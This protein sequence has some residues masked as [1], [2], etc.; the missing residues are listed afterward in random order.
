[1]NDEVL[2]KIQFNSQS[3][4]KG[5]RTVSNNCFADLLR[6]SF[7]CFNQQIAALNTSISE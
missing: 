5:N 6:S 2:F 3:E 4:N 7:L 1:M